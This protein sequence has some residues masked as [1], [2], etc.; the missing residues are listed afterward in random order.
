[1]SADR[2]AAMLT[3]VI[4]GRGG[5]TVEAPPAQSPALLVLPAVADLLAVE[6]WRRAG[7]S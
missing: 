7:S 2:P 6:L 1:M 3:S 5:A 4:A